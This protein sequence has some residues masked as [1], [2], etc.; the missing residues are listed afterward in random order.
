MPLIDGSAENQRLRSYDGFSCLHCE[1]RTINLTLIIQHYSQDLPNYPQHPRR[2]T[3]RADI[4]TYFEYVYLQAWASGSS[5]AYWIVERDGRL[6][7]PAVPVCSMRGPVSSSRG[8]T[9]DEPPD[10]INSVQAR[11][12][13]RNHR[14]VDDPC[15][16]GDTQTTAAGSATT[17]AEQRPWLE[18]TRW[19]RCPQ[20]KG[21]QTNCQINQSNMPKSYIKQTN[22]IPWI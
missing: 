22:S 15:R 19:Q 7:R 12:H 21:N 5:R 18:R 10:L 20:I 2:P 14:L 16:V 1:Y 4:E 11:E 17:Y 3:R 8:R 6:V 13:Q 9:G